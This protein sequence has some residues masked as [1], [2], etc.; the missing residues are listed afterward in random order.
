M[1]KNLLVTLADKNYIN[2]AKQLFSSVYF[3]SGW[4]GDYMLLSHEIPEKDL[5]WFRKKR[6]LIKKCKPIYKESEIKPTKLFNPNERFYLFTPYFKKWKNIIYL[7]GDIIVEASIDKLTEIK[8]FYAVK[9]FPLPLKEQFDYSIKTKNIYDNL[10]KNYNFKINSFN[11]GVMA[12]STDII[13]KNS[14]MELLKLTGEYQK[15]SNNG[16]QSILN[17]YFYKKWKELPLV[18]NFNPYL[19]IHPGLNF[20]K[21][22]KLKSIIFHFYGKAKPW[23]TRTIFY[24]KFYYEWEKNLDKAELIDI[25]NPININKSWTEKEIKRYSRF[26]KIKI[27]IYSPIRDIRRAVGLIFIFIKNSF[28]KLYSKLKLNRYHV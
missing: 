15:V 20:R 18:Y 19:I 28:P 21:N 2:Q 24:N 9:D 27:I 7:D 6:I 11:D 13:N 26:L 3:N 17:L 16:D 1:K 8:G 10:K 25:K 5:K 22:H 14:F 12:F 4:K 23:S